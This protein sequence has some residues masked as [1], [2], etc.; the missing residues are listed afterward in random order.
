MISDLGNQLRKLAPLD[1]AV[2][3]T[4]AQSCC[5]V[6]RPTPRPPAAVLESGPVA[7][8]R[9]LDVWGPPRPEWKVTERMKQTFDPARILNRGRYVGGI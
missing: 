6:S 8:R 7:L 3:R 9:Q 2:T 1:S 4:A 5:T